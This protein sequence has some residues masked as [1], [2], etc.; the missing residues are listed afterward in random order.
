VE[1]HKIHEIDLQTMR[2]GGELLL[3]LLPVAPSTPSTPSPSAT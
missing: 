1:K 2:I 3:E